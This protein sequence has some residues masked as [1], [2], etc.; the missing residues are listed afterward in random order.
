[1]TLVRLSSDC[2]ITRIAQTLRAPRSPGASS[3]VDVELS[4][5]L[6]VSDKM[7]TQTTLHILVIEIFTETVAFQ[8][9]SFLR[10]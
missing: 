8:G 7:P 6:M 1:M 10:F 4:T 3:I 5:T 2:P 9:C